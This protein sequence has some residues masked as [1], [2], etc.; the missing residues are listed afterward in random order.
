M[1]ITWF[2]KTCFRLHVGGQ[3]IVVDPELAPPEISTGELISGADR[4]VRKGEAGLTQ[5]DPSGWHRRRPLLAVDGDD[6]PP[7][8]L[9][10]FGSGG[11]F[12]DAPGEAPLIVCGDKAL[13]NRFA[14]DAVIV[15]AGPLDRL[16]ADISAIAASARP[17]LVALAS[18]QIDEA[19]FP[20]LANAA[21]GTPLQLLEPGLALEA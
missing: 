12:V 9:S 2:A 21:A 13:W 1:K 14:D 3:I 20:A 15:L 11:L 5:F 7:P 17:R 19:H 10:R 18:H 8:A 16:V 4:I 6:A